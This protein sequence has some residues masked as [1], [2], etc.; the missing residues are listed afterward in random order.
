MHTI[1]S[2]WYA[3]AR[4]ARGALIPLTCTAFVQQEC[5]VREGTGQI[6][7]QCK[8]TRDAKVLGLNAA[9]EKRSQGAGEAPSAQCNESPD[10]LRLP[11]QEGMAFSWCSGHVR[12]SIRFL[13]LL[14]TR[15]PPA[16]GP[17]T[18]CLDG[19]TSSEMPLDWVRLCVYPMAVCVRAPMKERLLTICACHTAVLPQ[20]ACCCSSASRPTT[21]ERVAVW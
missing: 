2:G 4:V 17:C 6:M 13:A 11:S 18:D 3:D 7:V 5:Y 8:A 9:S 21:A 19:S 10:D 16:C 1:V 12:S 14:R 20:W 15:A